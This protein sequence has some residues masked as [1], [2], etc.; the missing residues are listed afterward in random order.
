M[1]EE[2]AKDAVESGGKALCVGGVEAEGVVEVEGFIVVQECRESRKMTRTAQLGTASSTDSTLLLF[3]Q[4]SS[5]TTTTTA[6][7]RQSSRLTRTVPCRRLLVA[8]FATPNSC[9]VPQFDKLPPRRTFVSTTPHRAAA[10]PIPTAT[11]AVL[12]RSPTA[13]DIENAELD[14]EPLA[15]TDAQLALTERAAEVC[16]YYTHSSTH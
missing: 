5:L 16:L 1:R 3:A 4:M 15:Q 13:E 14:L 7:L 11:Q 9:P 10:A 2:R 8:H 6:L 12:R